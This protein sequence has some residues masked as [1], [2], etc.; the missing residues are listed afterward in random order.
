M[1]VGSS[2]L[3][4]DLGCGTDNWK[5]VLTLSS[6]ILSK[7]IKADTVDNTDYT[8]F[9]GVWLD[10]SDNKINFISTN[11]VRLLW[12]SRETEVNDFKAIIPV[13]VLPEI[14]KLI[15]KYEK[16]LKSYDFNTIIINKD[17][18]VGFIVGN[19][20]V[21]T[22]TIASKFPNYKS[23]VIHNIPNISSIVINTSMLRIAMQTVL[24]KSKKDFLVTFN[25]NDDGIHITGQNTVDVSYADG[26]NFKSVELKL[27]GNY[28]LDFL[29][30]I[31]TDIVIFYYIEQGRPVE[32]KAV[33][34]V[35]YFY[36]ITS[37]K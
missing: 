25:I 19:D 6:N 32:F 35:E 11:R 1:L 23:V 22:D 10:V 13:D 28:V 36:V 31:D 12:I 33:S 27:N 2:K 4:M 7:L 8:E 14:R 34:N 5:Q 30:K 3:L 9:G 17:N 15:L 37:S 29:N 21:I 18:Y 26:L 20:L 16:L 24:A